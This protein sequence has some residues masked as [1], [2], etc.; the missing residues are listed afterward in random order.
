[1]NYFY[2][3]YGKFEN[4]N[5]RIFFSH[6][7]SLE[8][9][10]KHRLKINDFSLTATLIK[11]KANN[12]IINFDQLAE[13]DFVLFIITLMHLEGN[14]KIFRYPWFPCTSVHKRYSIHEIF[15][16]CSSNRYFEKVK[17]LFGVNN[18][19]EFKKLIND[20]IESGKDRE[21]YRFEYGIQNIEVATNLDNLA[22]FD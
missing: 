16:K 7:Q 15:I 5:I 12:K 18:A 11:R 21:F 17:D 4:A 9:L 2:K 19:S 20:V 14:K 1:M 22:V 6:I 10:R 13:T 8:E 3:V